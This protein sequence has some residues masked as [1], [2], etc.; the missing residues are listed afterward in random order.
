M[1]DYIIPANSKKGVLY[2]NMFTGFD[3]GI[4]GTGALLTLVL[5]FALGGTNILM[6]VISL[7]PIGIAL[8]LVMPVANY[9]NVRI[10]IK[11][12]YVFY[13]SQR[14]YRW[15]GWCIKDVFRGEERK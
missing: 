6:A 8:L 12:M 5:F 9:H 14:K 2:F 13:I 3:L 11:E 10:F 15:R 1:N 4:I 7:L